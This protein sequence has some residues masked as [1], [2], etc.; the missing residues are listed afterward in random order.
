MPN[1]DLGKRVPIKLSSL[2]PCDLM[3]K[4]GDFTSLG[5]VTHQ[6]IFSV[7][8]PATFGGVFP[9]EQATHFRHN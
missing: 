5:C 3:G 8:F 4:E 1:A 9:A 6:S 7:P 2:G